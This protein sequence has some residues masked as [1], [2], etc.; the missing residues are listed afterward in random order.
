MLSAIIAAVIHDAFHPGT[1]NAFMVNTDHPV[2]LQYNDQ[3]VLENQ[4]LWKCLEMMTKSK[5]TKN[6]PK[7][8]QKEMR[9][10]IIAMVLAT[11]MALHFHVIS[12][13]SQKLGAGVLGGS[14]QLSMEHKSFLL[15]MA[16]KVADIGHTTLH[17]EEHL[18]WVQGLQEEFFLQGDMER[19]K[20]MG[21]SPLCDRSR[22]RNGPASG[23]N[24]IGF[25]DVICIPLVSKFVDVF[26]LCSSIRE[27]L[28]ANYKFWQNDSKVDGKIK[29]SNSLG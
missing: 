28:D 2:A 17:H 22:S 24:Q 1:N 16:I 9:K 4:S 10:T 25:F 11:D 26:P 15:Q 13:F 8:Q 19:E 5:F 23:E 3:H 20:K 18:A 12:Q 27:Q 6:M 21:I 29:S 14:K 7:V